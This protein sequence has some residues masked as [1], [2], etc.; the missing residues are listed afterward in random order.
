MMEFLYES[1]KDRLI[2]MEKEMSGISSALISRKFKVT[3][4]MAI[5]LKNKFYNEKKVETAKFI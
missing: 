4:D 1:I 3:L 5:K 2:L